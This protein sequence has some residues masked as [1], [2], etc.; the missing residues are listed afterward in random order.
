VDYIL[1]AG[2]LTDHAAIGYNEVVYLLGGADENGSVLDTVWKYDSV[3]HNYT[4]MAP[5]PQPRYRFGAAI[6]NSKN[7]RA[8]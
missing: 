4:R 2:P 7:D 8:H 1:S 3:F 6:I 5:M